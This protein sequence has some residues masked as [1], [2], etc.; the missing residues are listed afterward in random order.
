MS[1][2]LA[3]IAL[4]RPIGRLIARINFRIGPPPLTGAMYR[5]VMQL[6][7]PGDIILTRTSPRPTNL[8]IP[9]KWGH[10]QL[11]K[12]DAFGTTVEAT[13]PLVRESTLVDVWANASEVML[14]RP[15]WTQA[16]DGAAAFKWASGHVGKQYD[17]AFL[18]SSNA[19]Y[20]SEL[21][22][23]AYDAAGAHDVP[24]HDLVTDIAGRKVIIPSTLEDRRHFHILWH[25]HA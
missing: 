6:A 20:C 17:T 16:G 18:L 22:I 3:A 12:G 4:A 21:A 11:L 9:G 5:E 7:L 19:F 1:L 2:R 14:I 10:V 15:R 8:F 13:Y 25:S 24:W 23:M